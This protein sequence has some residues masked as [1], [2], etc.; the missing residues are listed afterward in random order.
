MALSVQSNVAS[1]AAQRQVTGT[2]K[3]LNSAM[4]RL[5]SGLRINSAADSSGTD[6]RLP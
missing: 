2:E 6:R 4:A 3:S 1:F 5:S